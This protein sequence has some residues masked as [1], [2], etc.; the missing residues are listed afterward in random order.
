MDL[1]RIERQQVEIKTLRRMLPEGSKVIL[2]DT[3]K[4]DSRSRRG[5]FS[6]LNSLIVLYEGEI[7]NRKQGHYICLIPR[8]THIEYF[9]SLGMS[10]DHE[11]SILGLDNKVFKQLLGKN[12]KYSRVKLQRDRYDV[13]DC[14]LW[15]VARAYL[16]KIKLQDFQKLF[17]KKVSLQSTDDRV[18]YMTYLLQKLQ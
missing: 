11:T 16:H 2:Y 17:L 13:N 3:L 10:P 1:K 9:S 14:A 15:C 7:D 6:G 18:A 5:I 4:K 8:P 12:Y